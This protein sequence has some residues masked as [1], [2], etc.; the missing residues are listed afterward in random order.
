MPPEAALSARARPE[1]PPHARRSV[2]LSAL[3]G[4]KATLRRHAVHSVCEEARCP[5]AGEC[6]AQRVATFMIL[7]D[8]CTR[9]CR[10]CAV[11]SGSPAG[12]DPGEAERVAEAA[13]ELGL[14]HVVVTSVAR[15]DLPDG[16][17]GAFVRTVRAVRRRVPGARI[18]VLV[19]DF[20][21][22]PGGVAAV[23][24]SGIDVFNH[25]LETVERLQRSIRS[26][27][28]YGRSLSVLR[29][30]KALRGD[31][32]TKS[33]IMLGLGERWEEVAR[34]LEDLRGAGVDLVTV[35]QYLRPEGWNLPVVEFAPPERFEEVRRLGA[36][37]GFR[38]VEAGPFVR[39]SYHAG[40]V[41]RAAGVAPP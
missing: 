17:A 23:V 2:R 28:D 12:E 38:R 14:D 16:G 41:A 7:G 40:E 11:A 3:H 9:A 32:P 25:N 18:E 24:H 30:A 27:A 21:G 4:V 5:N 13:F 26:R 15:D 37:L 6:F 20:G 36:E 10:F 29:R 39:S 8:V 31:L 35:G 22:D 34:T 33:G 19:P 1:R